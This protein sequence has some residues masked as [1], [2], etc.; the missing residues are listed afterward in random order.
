MK[1]GEGDIIFI[2]GTDT[3]AGKSYATGWLAAQIAEEGKSVATMKFVQTGNEGFSEDIAVHRSIMGIA[4]LPED[5][6]GL[7]APEIYTYPASPS[8][9]AKIDRRPVDLRKIETAMRT[10]A[11][12]Y[13]VLLVE[14]AGGLMVPLDYEGTLTIDFPLA[15]NLPVALVTNGKLGSINHTILALEALKTR[16]MI[17]H[18]L[19]Y[20]THFD[21]DTV[22]AEDSLEYMKMYVERLFPGTPVLLVP[23][24]K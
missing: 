18:S 22:I 7:T 23:S 6:S 20:N 19:L 9:A 12:N 17:L 14:G 24:I 1:Q 8:L 10:L 4:S 15:N 21:Y 16:G 13:D 5:L 11:T 3:D 2:S